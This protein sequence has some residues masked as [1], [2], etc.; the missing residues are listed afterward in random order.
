MSNTSKSFAQLARDRAVLIVSLLFAV[1]ALLALV[2]AG[3]ASAQA[4]REASDQPVEVMVPAFERAQDAGDEITDKRLIE[5]AE[6]DPSSTR[7]IAEENNTP[8]WVARGTNGDVCVLYAM[9]GSEF[10]GFSCGSPS[11]LETHGLSVATLADKTGQFTEAYLV[12]ADVSDAL[13]KATDRL[14]NPATG[15]FTRFAPNENSAEKVIE[16]PRGD[17]SKTTFV[18]SELNTQSK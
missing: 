7:L 1:L 16:I 8:F 2:F 9:H 11:T 14:N 13:A 10:T 12:P 4:S 18:F 17:G 15:L 6:I 5:A 3:Y